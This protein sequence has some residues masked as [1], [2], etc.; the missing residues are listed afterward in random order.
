MKEADSYMLP[1]S[2]CR[3]V[4]MHIVVFSRLCSHTSNPHRAISHITTDSPNALSSKGNIVVF[5][6]NTRAASV[7]HCH[8]RW[9]AAIWRTPSTPLLWSCS[10][11]RPWHHSLLSKFTLIL[12]SQA[13]YIMNHQYLKKKK[14]EKDHV[15]I[16]NA[17]TGTRI[18]V[19][20]LICECDQL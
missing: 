18:F 1:F 15:E 9:T 10:R 2:L 5:Y 14:G 20:V 4:M 7:Q 11:K 12:S 19:G 3:M 13:I 8:R 16:L 17:A 6:N